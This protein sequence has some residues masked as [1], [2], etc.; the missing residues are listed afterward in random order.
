[1]TSHASPIFQAKISSFNGGERLASAVT[2]SS[3]LL[4]AASRRDITS[5]SMFCSFSFVVFLWWSFFLLHV[6]FRRLLYIRFSFPTAGQSNRVNKAGV[7]F[8]EYNIHTAEGTLLKRVDG[9][10]YTYYLCVY[11]V[12]FFVTVHSPETL[13]L[14][15]ETVAG[16]YILNRRENMPCFY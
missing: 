15:Y 3:R 4:L 14:A 11:R 8:K 2:N 13:E 9:D 16:R 12:P 6:S 10:I 1:M 7:Y 5:S